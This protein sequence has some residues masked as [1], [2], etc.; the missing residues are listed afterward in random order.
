[1]AKGSLNSNGRIIDGFVEKAKFF[2]PVAVGSSIILMFLLFKKGYKENPQ[3]TW[4]EILKNNF[5]VVLMIFSYALYTARVHWSLNAL[6]KCDVFWD[7]AESFFSPCEHVFDNLCKFIL[8]VL[9]IVAGL[10]FLKS[11]IFFS[12]V[13]LGWLLFAILVVSI[14]WQFILHRRLTETLKTGEIEKNNITTAVSSWLKLDL[15]LA[16]FLLFLN[17]YSKTSSFSD[18]PWIKADAFLWIHVSFTVQ[19]IYKNRAVYKLA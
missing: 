2:G 4:E 18:F 3:S 16:F 13:K 15:L 14:I 12:A 7:K 5:A 10:T 1:M 11:E 17:V 6:S 8:A 9:L 19:D